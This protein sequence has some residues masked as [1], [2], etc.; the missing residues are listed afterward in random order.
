MID[1]IIRF[2]FINICIPV[3][4]GYVP[5]FFIKKSVAAIDLTK[6]NVEAFLL[7]FAS[8]FLIQLVVF[9]KEEIPKLKADIQALS[10][11]TSAEVARIIFD[12]VEKDLKSFAGYLDAYHREFTNKCLTVDCQR[13]TC[14]DSVKKY[15]C[16]LDCLLMAFIK[17][18]IGIFKQS[19]DDVKEG[20]YKLDRDIEEYHTIA[21]KQLRLQ[22]INK[23]K[24]IHYI[25]NN[26]DGDEYDEHFMD[27]LL[28][29]NMK[30]D[31]NWLFVGDMKNFCSF[32]YLHKYLLRPQSNIRFTFL[33]ISMQNFSKVYNKN[34]TKLSKYI[35]EYEP[36]IG[37]YGVKFFFTQNGNGHGYFHVGDPVK[38]VD[39]LFDDLCK[40][41]GMIELR[42][43]NDRFEHITI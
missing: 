16:R 3:V 21:I 40:H 6:F 35:A 10:V 20:K 33:N 38:L 17:E 4:I 29:D 34:K 26:M 41:Q 9:C 19:L 23:L 11:D 43:N 12:G 37:I 31:I 36:N 13:L 30:L 8:T 18:D 7:S 1:K 24:V 42:H 28:N 15:E 39:N 14:N 22:S 2:I 5:E 32:K 25:D 27:T